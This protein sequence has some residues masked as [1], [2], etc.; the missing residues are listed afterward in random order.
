MKFSITITGT[1]DPIEGD[2]PTDPAEIR[3]FV[4]SAA[5]AIR[6]AVLFAQGEGFTHALEDT[7]AI[8]VESIVLDGADEP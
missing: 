8:E 5:E 6:N 7:T 2:V 1:I 3:R 4:Q